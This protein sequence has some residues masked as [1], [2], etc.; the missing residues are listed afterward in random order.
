MKSL[1]PCLVLA[2]AATACDQPQPKAAVRAE[3]QAPAPQPPQ[4]GYLE[5]GN[6]EACGGEVRPGTVKAYFERLEAHLRTSSDPVPLEFY[7]RTVSI[8]H[9]GRWLWF[10]V[11]DLGPRARQLPSLADWREISRRGAGAIHG[12][13]W[14][15]CGLSPGKVWFESTSYDGIALKGFDKDMDWPD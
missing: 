12:A 4:P 6:F 7:S 15:G 1:L 5:V 13:G 14:R 11:K 8:T 2:L 9:R 3:T 10:H